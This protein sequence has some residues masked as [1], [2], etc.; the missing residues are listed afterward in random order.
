MNVLV[1][2]AT[3]TIGTAVT[4]E[5][6]RAGHDVLAL[7]RS[8][9][10]DSKLRG[11]GAAVLRG[12]L[13]QPSEWCNAVADCDTVVQV[14]ATF[15]DDM[16]PVDLNLLKTLERALVRSGRRIKIIYTGGCW[17]YG[18]TGDAVADETFPFRPIAP[19]SWMVDNAAFLSGSPSFDTTIIHPAMVY[20]ANGGVVARYIAQAKAGGPVEIWGSPDARWPLVHRDD[21]AVA[22][23]ILVEQTKLTGHFNVAAEAGVRTGAIAAAIS[24][25]F[26]LSDRPVTRSVREVTGE[27][28][29]WAEGPTLDQ[30]MSAKKFREAGKWVPRHLSFFNSIT[31]AGSDS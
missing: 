2:G 15:E 24:A 26:G 13:R 6:L 9:R 12:D 19:F 10:A 1:L 7:S 23:R 3:G 25:H 29:A 17:L 27:Y 11:Q 4:G 14:A 5:L 30:Q 31:V 22:Y 28:G 21:L 20:H 16:G 18:A 8:E